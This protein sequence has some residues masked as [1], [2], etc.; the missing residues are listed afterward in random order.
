MWRRAWELLPELVRRQ[1]TPEILSD[2]EEIRLRLGRQPS[3]LKGGQEHVFSE[4][5]ITST[6][7]EN[8]LEKATGA[9]MH[10]VV[11]TIRNGYLSYRGIRIGICGTVV[12]DKGSVETFRTLTSLAIRIP[13][14]CPN[15]CRPYLQEYCSDTYHNTLILSAPGGG[16]TTALRDMIQALSNRGYRIAVADERNELASFDGT[17]P[18]FD[19]GAHTDVLIGAPKRTSVMM[20]LRSMNPQLLAMDEI[21]EEEDCEIVRQIL[22]CGVGL[23]ATAH[24][25]D[26]SELSRR[27]LYSGLLRDRVFD[28]ALTIRQN[29]GRRTYEAERLTT[30]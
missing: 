13:R 17:Q 8:I 14:S 25:T 1:N 29:D 2:T 22:G 5:L 19:L 9:S 7:L 16:K 24:A 6:I 10:A 27:P 26:A 21:S 12:M 18:G 28:F 15:I 4:V 3:L 20:L 11:H 23:L 30:C